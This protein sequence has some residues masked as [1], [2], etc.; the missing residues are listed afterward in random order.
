MVD[1]DTTCIKTKLVIPKPSFLFGNKE[2]GKRLLSS[3]KK[4]N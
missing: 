2:K 4:R 3:L 1:K